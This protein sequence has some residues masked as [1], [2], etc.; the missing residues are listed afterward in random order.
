MIICLRLKNF[1]SIRDEVVLDFTADMSY[2]KAA[3]RLPENLIEFSSDKFVNVIGLFGSN[4][5]G[6]SNIIKAISFCRQLVLT[7]HLNN[8]DDTLGIEPFKFDSDKPSEFYMDFVTGGI[9]YEYSFAISRGEIVSEE[10]YYYPNKRKAKVFSRET[11]F[12]YSHRRSVIERP[13]EVEANTGPKTLFISRASSMNRQIAHMVYRF[14]K[15]GMMIGVEDFDPAKMDRQQFEELKPV[16]LKALEVSDSDIV[17]IQY[18]E[19]TPGIPRLY[20]F[21]KENPKIPFDFAKEESDGTKR[22]FNVLIMM[23]KKALDGA[24]IFLDEFDLKLHVRLA[25][26]LLDLIR[27]SRGGQ[28][29]FTS[30]NPSLIDTTR[31]RPEQIVFVNKQSDGN[32]EFV[33][34]S[35]YEGIGKGTDIRKAYLQGRFDAVPY[36]GDIYPILSELISKK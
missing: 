36:I 8:E 24:A 6:K 14:F 18:S 22:L 1:F 27:A 13:T 35:D 15:N 31:L 34:L 33:P 19:L 12:S 20:S 21:H 2:R 25:E 17:D 30:H 10:L 9:E 29:V 32:S 4:A 28:I 7:S 3:E 26:F 23:L 16:L 5:A 11:T